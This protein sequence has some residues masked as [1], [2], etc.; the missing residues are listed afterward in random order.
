MILTTK[1]T[2]NRQTTLQLLDNLSAILRTANIAP[3]P[4]S[5]TTLST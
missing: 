1:Q 2:L 3:Q 5:C 4:I